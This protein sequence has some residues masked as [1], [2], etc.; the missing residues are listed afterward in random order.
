MG[1]I[2]Y[3]FDKLAFDSKDFFVVVEVFGNIGP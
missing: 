2:V 3:T 1:I